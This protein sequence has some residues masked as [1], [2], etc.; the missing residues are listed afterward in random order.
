MTIFEDIKADKDNLTYTEKGLNPVFYTPQS[1]KILIIGQAPGKKV[2]ETEIMW[3]DASGDRLR[4]WLDVDRKQFYDSGNFG[5]ISM[6]FY[7]PG[8]AKSGDKPPRG[9]IAKKWHPK[10]IASMP[11]LQLI[12]LI[13]SYAQKYYLHLAR[14]EKITDV[15]KNYKSYLPKYFPIIHPSPRNNIWLNRNPWFEKEVV[16][17]LQAKVSDTI[18]E[19]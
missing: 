4:E 10:L 13:G 19:K 5:F 1:A 3:N 2:Q 15:V 6:D 17:R 18:K 11:N 9:S 12:F 16:P 7:Y 14:T 8:K